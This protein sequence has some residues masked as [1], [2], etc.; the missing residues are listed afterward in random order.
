V[1]WSLWDTCSRAHCTSHYVVRENLYT[2]NRKYVP[3]N[4]D[5]FDFGE[6]SVAPLAACVAALQVRPAQGVR[7]A[8]GPP[9]MRTSVPL[10]RCRAQRRWSCCPSQ[11]DMDRPGAGGGQATALASASASASG[12]PQ[13]ALVGHGLRQ[14]LEQLAKL[15]VSA[16]LGSGMDTQCS[17]THLHLHLHLHRMG[18]GRWAPGAM[19]QPAATPARQAGRR[20]W[21]LDAPC[22]PRPRPLRRLLPVSAP[23]PPPQV[24]L[25]A[26]ALVLDTQELHWARSAEA[27]AARRTISL[28]G[29]LEAQGLHPHDLHNAGNDARWTAEALLRLLEGPAADG[30]AGVA[31]GN[32]GA[33][34]AG[35]AQLP[36]LAGVAA[37]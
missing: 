1:G 37:S 33:E 29:L 25:P 17:G 7:W 6:S 5:N 15:G 35:A 22:A 13:L 2:R 18:A 10:R 23:P 27:G 20:G 32:A 26:G 31:G 14:D 36:A 3:D 4:K 30:A 24:S 28:K 9:H 16:A 12:G 19:P 21:P 8:L 34:R 11:A